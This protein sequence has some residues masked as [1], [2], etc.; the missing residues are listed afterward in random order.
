MAAT[1]EALLPDK[2]KCLQGRESLASI[3]PGFILTG[4]GGKE[5]IREEIFKQNKII[6]NARG[7]YMHCFHCSQEADSKFCVPVS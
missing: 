2:G 1:R 7:T 5:E 6:A 4:W 3:L